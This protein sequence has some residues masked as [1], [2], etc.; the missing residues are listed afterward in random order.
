[1]KI[2]STFTFNNLDKSYKNTYGAKKA[3][4]QRTHVYDYTV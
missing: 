2:R 1:M 3:T 4:Y